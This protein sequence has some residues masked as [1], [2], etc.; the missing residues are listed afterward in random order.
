GRPLREGQLAAL[1]TLT[2]DIL[3]VGGPGGRADR[4]AG[5]GPLGGLHTALLES[6]GERTIVLACDMPYV[7]AAMLLHLSTLAS[8]VDAV[9]PY[10]DCG[11]H[12]LCAVYAR[13]CLEPAMRRL[14]AGRL[15]MTD[16][17]DD[18]RVRVV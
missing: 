8:D 17:L 9:V 5:C 3:I 10:T 18:L 12:P 6:K 4:I 2:S 7:T 1:A 11:Y 14:A 16:L 13:A 15:K